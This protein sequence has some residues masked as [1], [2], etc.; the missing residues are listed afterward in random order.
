MFNG[1]EICTK[2]EKNANCAKHFYLKV[3]LGTSF[4]CLFQVRSG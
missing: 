3:V 1:N 4:E 2:I